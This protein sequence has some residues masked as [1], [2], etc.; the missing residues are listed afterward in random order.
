MARFDGGRFAAARQAAGLSR[1]DVADRL[2]VSQPD[3]IRI[4]EEGLEEPR[5]PMIPR[6]AGLVAMDSMSLL[7][8][9]GE[10]PSLAALRLAAG[11]SRA[12]VVAAAT[13]LTTM[14]YHRLD[15]GTG[16]RR[17]PDPATIAELAQILGCS[18]SAVADGIAQ[19]RK[20]R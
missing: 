20:L 15:T 7:S 3:R 1:R 12:D 8:G 13:T 11:L 16:A 6:L 2:G 5:P 19:A 17:L 4:W 10:P 9:T 18:P 14:T